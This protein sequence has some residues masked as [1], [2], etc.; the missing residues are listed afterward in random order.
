MATTTTPGARRRHDT[1]VDSTYGWGLPMVVGILMILAGALALYFAVLTS[2]LSVLYL[3]I[4]MLAIG[5]M[6]IVAAFRRR[7]S[8]QFFVYVLAGVL[9]IVVGA[10]FIAR[11]LASMASL[12]LVIAGYLFASG[13]FRGVAAVLDRY[14]QWGWDLTYAIITVVFGAYLIASWPISGLWLLGTLV[15]AEIMIRGVTLVA[16]SLVIRDIE[17]HPPALAV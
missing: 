15:A 4:L 12:G 14:P 13:L 8:G 11:P 5:V 9:A 6:E 3:G 7:A 2:Y 10:L 1:V 17:H 16:A